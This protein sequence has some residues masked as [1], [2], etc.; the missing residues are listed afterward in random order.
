[1]RRENTAA[2]RGELFASQR[3][4]APQQKCL[5]ILM[6]PDKIVLASAGFVRQVTHAPDRSNA[7]FI[8]YAFGF[9]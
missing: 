3:A 6:K 2:I 7:P 9:D 8:G 5:L 4:A 1:L